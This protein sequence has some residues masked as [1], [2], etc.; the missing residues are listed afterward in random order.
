MSPTFSILLIGEFVFALHQ[1]IRYHILEICLGLRPYDATTK[2]AITI[3]KVTPIS[4]LKTKVVLISLACG[5]QHPAVTRD[6]SKKGLPYSVS[7]REARIA[8]TLILLPVDDGGEDVRVH[9]CL[10]PAQIN[11]YIKF[12]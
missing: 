1:I 11:G 8:E 4:I 9:L 12:Y 7:H 2:P 3:F 6:S 5:R 10:R